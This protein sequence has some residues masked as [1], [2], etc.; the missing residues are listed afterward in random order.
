M[1][2]TLFIALMLLVSGCK[3]KCVDPASVSS[4]LS[5]NLQAN[6][7]CKGIDAMNLDLNNW[8]ASM[9][10]C[11][12]EDMKTGVIADM[13]CPFIVGQLRAYA[14]G[15]IPQN[16]QCDPNKIGDVAGAALESLCKLIP[17]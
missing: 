4:L 9:N 2:K 3:T 1:K 17:F 10:L 7:D 8:F 11:Q 16:W 15:Q 5:K 12:K 13:A 6:W 14:A